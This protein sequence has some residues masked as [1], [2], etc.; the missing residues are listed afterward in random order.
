MAQSKHPVL[1]RFSARTLRPLLTRGGAW[2]SEASPHAR[3]RMVPGMKG[4]IFRV[5]GGVVWAPGNMSPSHTLACPWAGDRGTHSRTAVL[6]LPWRSLTATLG[7]ATIGCVL[8]PILFSLLSALVP[9]SLFRSGNSFGHHVSY[10]EERATYFPFFWPTVDIH[11]KFQVGQKWVIVWLFN[12][13]WPGL[14]YRSTVVCPLQVRTTQ[15]LLGP[16]PLSS[17]C[18]GHFIISASKNSFKLFL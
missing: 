6:L 8:L 4:Q 17:S 18:R 1:G 7:T 13:G 15:S 10:L 11:A 3:R 12:A 16:S 14:T 5:R 9:F 2:Y